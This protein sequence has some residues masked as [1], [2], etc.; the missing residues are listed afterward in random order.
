MNI[1]LKANRKQ[2]KEINKS[3]LRN[4][5]KQRRKTT[6]V[7][8]SQLTELSV[9]TVNSL[10]SEMVLSGEVIEGDDIPSN[11]GRPSKQYIYNENY[12]QSIIIYG[13]QNKNKNLFH[14]LVVDSF[15]AC[16]TR[17]KWYIEQV[18]NDSFCPWIE[19]ALQSY[20]NICT[21]VF[22]LPGAEENGV[23][24]VHDYPEIIG[25]QFLSYYREQYGVSVI[26][27]N[28][29]NATTLG[30]YS[31]QNKEMVRTVVGLYYPRIYGPGAGTVIKGEI[32]R[33]CKNFAG[34]VGWIPITPS[35]K[36]LNYD[37]PDEVLIMLRQI[38]V[39]YC[40]VLAPDSIV[41]YGDFLNHDILGSLMEQVQ[42]LLKGNFVPNISFEKSLEKDFELGLIQLVLKE[43]ERIEGTALWC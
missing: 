2:M 20:E 24:Y 33:G 18:M 41:I 37:N 14:M 26:Y 8:L 3:I 34:E 13:Y 35:W 6:K 5:L 4:T 29:I 23:I 17:K 11:G 39:M 7:E 28:D 12:R 31:R 42:T 16:L 9:V 25:D 15:G 27:E 43:Y 38:V 10:I 36:D 1:N 19:D 21:I 40:C 32:Y 30:F 22:G